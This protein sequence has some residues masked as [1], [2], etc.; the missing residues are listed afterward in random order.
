MQSLQASEDAAD[1]DKVEQKR[2]ATKRDLWA[3]GVGAV[4]SGNFFGW[5]VTLS[6]GF[7]SG[8]VALC[9]ASIFY[10]VLSAS[11]AE[12]A[13]IQ[14]TGA[15]PCQFAKACFGRRIAFVTGLAE[16]LKCIVVVG[17]ITTGIGSYLGEI[18]KTSAELAPAWWL[19]FMVVFTGLNIVGGEMS[20]NL[21]L[22]VTVAACIMLLVFYLGAMATGVDF[23]A[24]ALGGTGLWESTSIAGVWAAWPFALWF[25]LG[26]EEL[27]LAMEITVDPAQNMPRALSMSFATV[28][29]LAFAT[30][31]I[32]SSIPPGAAG[33]ATTTYPLLV[34]YQYVFGKTDTTRWCCVVLV[35]GLIASLHS[36][37]FVTGQLISQM[38]HDGY[39]PKWLNRRTQSGRPFAAII[40]GSALTYLITVGLYVAT[41]KNGDL[42]GAIAIAMC[43]FCTMISYM[44]QLSCF[45]WLRI[46]LPDVERQFCSPFGVAGALAGLLLC[47]IS[48]SAILCLP[49]TEISYLYGLATATVIL[50]AGTVAREASWNSTLEQTSSEGDSDSSESDA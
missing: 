20:K 47:A 7:G 37:I 1:I 14:G 33:M 15:G 42:I 35:T 25:Y 21:Q 6:N 12:V 8:L 10:M 2:T 50:A 26:I 36:F 39:F 49:S 17:V 5:Q 16:S 43:L 31:F 23:E 11:V 38:A 24:R 13:S 48:L 30:F 32:S 27:P 22:V 28:A 3:V 18:T 34:G 40:T 4:I 45:L 9:F 19:G 41:G 44:V 46:K 29:A